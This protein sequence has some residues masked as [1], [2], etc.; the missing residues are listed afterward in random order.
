MWCAR[1][2]ALCPAALQLPLWDRLLCV[3][4]D[5]FALPLPGRKQGREVHVQLGMGCRSS[6]RV[7]RA[8]PPPATC[9]WP[10]CDA[11][12]AVAASCCAS[13]ASLQTW[14]AGVC[15][16]NACAADMLAR[17][18]GVVGCVSLAA[19][20]CCRDS[21]LATRVCVPV[22][23]ALCSCHTHRRGQPDSV[24]QRHIVLRRWLLAQLCCAAAAAAPSC[25][26][27]RARGVLAGCL[28]LAVAVAVAVAVRSRA[29]SWSARA[30]PVDPLTPL[31]RQQGPAAA[32]VEEMCAALCCCCC[33][34]AH[35]SCVRLPPHYGITVSAG[36][37]AC[38]LP[39]VVPPMQGRGACGLLVPLPAPSASQAPQHAAGRS[40]SCVS[41]V[42]VCVCVFARSNPVCCDSA[43][44][45]GAPPSDSVCLATGWQCV[46]WCV[47]WCECWRVLGA[48]E[49]TSV[50]RVPRQGAHVPA[51]HLCRICAQHLCARTLSQVLPSV[52]RRRGCC[53]HDV[54]VG[55]LQ[56]P[57]CDTRACCGSLSH[58][59][60]RPLVCA[61]LSTCLRW[62]ARVC[63]CAVARRLCGGA[64]PVHA[65]H[66]CGCA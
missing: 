2:G 6:V 24:Q 9:C 62:C 11:R 14:A 25:S 32:G 42:C 13:C 43:W 53:R 36:D 19:H 1:Q 34:C 17:W 3:A 21:C 4:A 51:V 65:H 54:F 22:S 16:V 64:V 27:V 50:I 44:L 48:R 52:L 40:P 45:W 31:P 10:R 41:C 38:V 66:G 30:A 63:A 5:A 7:H 56:A 12:V 20:R 57:L 35:C 26:S 55:P 59:A 47:C 28:G 60:G 58:A 29:R 18:R 37:S 46:C 33:P 61:P 15:G 39:C 8:P 23:I 49:G